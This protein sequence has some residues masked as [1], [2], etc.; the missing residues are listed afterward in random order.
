MNAER[1]NSIDIARGIAIFFLVSMHV[2]YWMV[3]KVYAAFDMALFFFI[4]G[5]LIKDNQDVLRFFIGKVKRLYLP[6]VIVSTI[7]LLF[8]NVFESIGITMNRYDW[9]S[10]PNTFVHILLFDNVEILLIQI[11]FLP[12]LFLTLCLVYFSTKLINCIFDEQQA[13]MVLL[14]ESVAFY[15]INAIW[16]DR[17]VKWY[18]Y[19]RLLNC[20]SSAMIFIVVGYIISKKDIDIKLNLKSTIWFAICVCMV[21]IIIRY[22][23]FGIDV[24]QNI[25]SNWVIYLPIT[26][27]GIYITFYFAKVLD[28]YTKIVRN[29]LSYLGENTLIILFLHP[30]ILN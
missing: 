28:K 9:T 20:I 3:T 26:F 24:R 18:C 7:F 30:L 21:V 12:T 29:V 19:C 10:G 25:C 23:N 13:L 6:F 17:F 4:S 14:L 1:K 8:H 5:Y 2:R 11:W 15:G 22:T 16:G 27:M